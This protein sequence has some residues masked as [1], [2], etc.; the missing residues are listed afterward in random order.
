MKMYYVLCTMLGEEIETTNVPK[1]IDSY[2]CA[3][4]EAEMYRP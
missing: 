4:N 2:G 1:D 3:A